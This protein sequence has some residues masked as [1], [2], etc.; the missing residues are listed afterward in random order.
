MIG[1]KYKAYYIPVYVSK[2]V[3][4]K[5]KGQL[6]RLTKNKTVCHIEKDQQKRKNTIAEKIGEIFEN[7]PLWPII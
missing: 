5:K 7:F 4:K 3:K 2:K 1:D 6:I